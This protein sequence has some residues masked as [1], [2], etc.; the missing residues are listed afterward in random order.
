[1]G[2]IN[3]H[4]EVLVLEFS[5]S[6]FSH[7]GF[8]FV[9]VL[10][11]TKMK[12]V[13]I[14]LNWGA[15]SLIIFFGYFLAVFTG[16]ELIPVNR[17]IPDLSFN[18]GGKITAILLWIVTL[19]LLIRLNANFKAADAGFRLK[20]TEGSIKPAVIVTILFVFLQLIL[21]TILGEGPN[22]DFEQ[23]VFQATIPGFDE[24]PMFRGLILYTF[25]LAVISSRINIFGAQI[26]IAGLLLVLLFG[27]LHGIMYSGGEWHFSIISLSITGVYG[28]IL[29]WL[30]ERTG[31]LVF[32]IIAHN[33]VNFSGLFV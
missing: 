2:V 9:I 3:H 22:Y 28:F 20:Q 15:L 18:W 13:T 6:F 5:L 19:F 11:L 25:S 33:L 23:L 12:K 30:R 27:L 8:I 26:N 24:E 1:M 16:S 31:S 10:T 29:L 4:K 7:A 32:P 17:I 14:N 21:S